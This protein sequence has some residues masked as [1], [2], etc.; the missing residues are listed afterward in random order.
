MFFTASL[1]GN[2][3]TNN[4]AASKWMADIQ[5]DLE[6]FEELLKNNGSELGFIVID[7][8]TTKLM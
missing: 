3:E 5:F 8:K 4:Q 6:Q 1:E 7:Y 2:R